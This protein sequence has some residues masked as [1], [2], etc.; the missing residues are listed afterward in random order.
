M[1]EDGTPTPKPRGKRVQS[2]RPAGPTE[3]PPARPRVM[4]SPDVGDREPLSWRRPAVRWALLAVAVV[5]LLGVVV[6]QHGGRFVRSDGG[7]V[8]VGETFTHKSGLVVNVSAPQEFTPSD[9]AALPVGEH[10]YQVIVAVRNGTTESIP[11]SSLEISATVDSTPARAL[12]PDGPL[13]QVIPLGMQLNLPFRF[14]VGDGTAR[15]LQISVRDAHDAA[16]HFN[17]TI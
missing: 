16:V 6:V 2:E 10:A 11:L 12:A 5:A 3:S 4:S 9:P 8:N 1:T 14:T 17:G 15:P 7:T 13:T